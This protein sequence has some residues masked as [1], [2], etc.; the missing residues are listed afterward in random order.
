MKRILAVLFALM[1]VT[2]M[3]FVSCA[4]KELT[5]DHA[6]FVMSNGSEPTIDP[7][8]LN[9][10][11]STNVGLG[12]FEGMMQYDPTTNKGIPA[13]AESYTVSS[14][15]LT[16]TCKLRKAQWSDGHPVTAD[17]FVYAMQR[18]LDPKTASDYAYMPGMLIKGADDYNSGKST[19]FSTVG[20]KALDPQTVQYT[21]VNPT[22]YF[23]DVLAHNSFWPLPK[24]A[25]DKYGTDWTKPGNIVTNGPYIL[26][27]WKPQDY[28]FLVKND[29]YWDAK[30]V[31]LRGIKILASDNDS[32]NYDMYKS[33]QVDWM[34]GIATSKIDEI[35]L[36]SDYQTSP[37]VATYY[38]EFNVTRKPVNNVLVREALASAIDKQTLVDKVTKG[39]QIPADSMVPPLP[40]YTPAK[41]Q[42]YNVEAAKKF[43]AQAGYPNGKG[44]PTLTIVYNTNEG[45]KAIAEY[46]QQQW[47]TNLGIN[48]VLKNMEFK[49]L[50]DLR[51]KAH[52]FTVARAGW[53]GDYM[54]PNTFLDMFVTGGGNNDTLYADPAYDKLIAD[55]RTAS[56]D[57]RMQILNQAEAKLLQENQV[58][59]P[60]YFYVNQNLVDTTK[61]G[62]WNATPLDFHPF[63]FIYRKK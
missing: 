34:H 57:A 50:I 7:S 12:L 6:D 23:L 28:V 49:T 61:W 19:D 33:G 56:G 20:I 42:G 59:I 58:V 43:L 16:V 1:A 25:I 36:R 13:M 35:K 5:A 27:E 3:L 30:N 8:L 37:Q 15:G 41:G 22:P 21:L 26:K 17:D 14:D 18:I 38:Y 60:I 62:G 54:D 29:K 32:T 39:G 9:D 40:G 24:W 55:A 46:I 52:D 48:V 4:P 51:A 44:F 53:V 47:K 2:T 63:K 45:H 10:V 31:H 11:P